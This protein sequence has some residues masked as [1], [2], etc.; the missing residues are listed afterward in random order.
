[1]KC[2]LFIKKNDFRIPV[3]L[4]VILA[5][6]FKHDITNEENSSNSIRFSCCYSQV[7]CPMAAA[8]IF[9]L[10]LEQKPNTG[11]RAA[12]PVC[13]APAVS[14]SPHH[15]PVT[16]ARTSCP[17]DAAACWRTSATIASQTCSFETCPDT[18]WSSRKTST[19]Q[20]VKAYQHFKTL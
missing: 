9:L 16:A 13:S 15:E 1:M 17:Q 19:D 14:F 12:P 18:W 10:P 8:V 3:Y 20:G 7:V 5:I 2:S 6:P 4:S 11:A